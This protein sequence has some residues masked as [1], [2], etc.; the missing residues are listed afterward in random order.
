MRLVEK[1]NEKSKSTTCQHVCT[2]VARFVDLP[3]ISHTSIGDFFYC[4]EDNAVYFN[5]GRDYYH[6]IRQINF[7]KEFEY[8]WF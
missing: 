1:I 8:S 2:H 5:I 3:P 7:E 4:L 6:V